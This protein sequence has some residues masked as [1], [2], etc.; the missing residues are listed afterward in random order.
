MEIKGFLEN[1]DVELNEGNKIITTERELSKT[2]NEHYINGIILMI[3]KIILTISPSVTKISIFIKQ[4][5]KLSNP[6]RSILVYC[7]SKISAHLH[8]M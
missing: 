8:F 6:T 2:F 1:K 5:G 3:L 4:L 7:K